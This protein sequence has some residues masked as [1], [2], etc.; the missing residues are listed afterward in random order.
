[1][2]KTRGRVCFLFRLDT[3]LPK[4]ENGEE[5]PTGN[6]VADG[7]RL[8]KSA[9]PGA[10]WIGDSSSS[11]CAAIAKLSVHKTV[12]FRSDFSFSVSHSQLLRLEACSFSELEDRSVSKLLEMWIEVKMVREEEKAVPCPLLP[13]TF[14]S[15]IPREQDLYLDTPFQTMS[16]TIT[17]EVFP[18]TQRHALRFFL[19]FTGGS[20]SP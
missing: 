20:L 8:T 5:F 3:I 18:R 19:N 7:A 12:I 9:E 6:R 14:D 13:L 15:P 10:V 16:R 11:R 17:R 4:S 2:F 1:M